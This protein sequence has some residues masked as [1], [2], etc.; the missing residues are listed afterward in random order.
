MLMGGGGEA[1]EEE[2]WNLDGERDGRQSRRVLRPLDEEID[3][4]CCRDFPCPR[5][6]MCRSDGSNSNLFRHYIVV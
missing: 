5:H 6:W 2:K 3:G 1:A 4:P